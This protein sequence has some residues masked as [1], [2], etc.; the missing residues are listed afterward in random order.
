MCKIYKHCQD[1]FA[2]NC[3]L[4]GFTLTIPKVKEQNCNK[5]KNLKIERKLIGYSI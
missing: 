5:K 3:F 1:L 2:Q 4:E